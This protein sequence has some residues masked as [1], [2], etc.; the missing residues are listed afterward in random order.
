MADVPEALEITLR[1]FKPFAPPFHRHIV[2][3][4]LRGAVCRVGDRYV[5]Y[6]VAATEPAGPV[7]VT[8][9]T[10]LRFE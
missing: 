10:L 1:K 7:Q 5:V 3:A 9:K 2:K 6:E 8:E 4:K